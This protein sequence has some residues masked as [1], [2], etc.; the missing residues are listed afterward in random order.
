[1]LPAF[2]QKKVRRPIDPATTAFIL[3][4]MV[5]GQAL[6][7]PRVATFTGGGAIPVSAP[8][9][10][11]EASVARTPARPI[12]NAG[13]LPPPGM[14]PAYR[15]PGGHRPPDD[16]YPPDD[17]RPPYDHHRHHDRGLF[18]VAPYFGAYYTDYDDGR[19]S[20]AVA[21]YGTAPDASNYP[22]PPKPDTHFVVDSYV[23]PQGRIG[24]P[25]RC[26][27]KFKLYDP[28]AGKYLATDGKAYSCQ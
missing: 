11:S 28:M 25:E 18:V 13:G 4:L 9:G 21:D 2:D 22:L 23:V 14:A 6:A 10:G 12:A 5:S 8:R 16:R 7:Q 20:P 26:A 27:A 24:W 3:G 15:P 1:M 17:H 19:A